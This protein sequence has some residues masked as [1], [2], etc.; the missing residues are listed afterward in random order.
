[1]SEANEEH[2]PLDGAPLDA[3]EGIFVLP[4]EI[5]QD[6]RIVVWYDE[7][8]LRL[9]REAQGVPMKTGQYTL[10]ERIASYYAKARYAELNGT[11]GS[12][13]EVAAA[14]AEWLKMIDI[15]NRLLEKN[16]DKVILEMYQ[17]VQDILTEGFPMITDPEDRK[18]F[19]RYLGEAFAEA[20]M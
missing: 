15:F 8:V 12:A 9:R 19:R 13:R 7:I 3:L 20:G 1:M 5:A 4:D 2:N 6:E 18:A 10:M 16:N 11:E 14:N 17:K